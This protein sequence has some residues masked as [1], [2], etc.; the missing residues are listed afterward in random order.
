MALAFLLI[1]DENSGDE[2]YRVVSRESAARHNKEGLWDDLYAKELVIYASDDLY[3]DVVDML[4]ACD[5]IVTPGAVVAADWLIH[6][7]HTPREASHGIDAE[8]LAKRHPRHP[9]DPPAA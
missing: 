4:H 3:A 1:E 2:D 5:T 9:A 6:L 8:T 7:H